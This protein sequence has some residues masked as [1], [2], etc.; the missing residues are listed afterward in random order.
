MINF[1]HDVR[2]CELNMKPRDQKVCDKTVV[3]S[4]VKLIFLGRDWGYI[5]VLYIFEGLI[6]TC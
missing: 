4:E 2:E 5:P 6:A 1:C 3:N